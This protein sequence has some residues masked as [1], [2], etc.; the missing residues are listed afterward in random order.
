VAKVFTPEALLSRLRRD[1]RYEAISAVASLAVGL[2]LVWL[3]GTGASLS[4]VFLVFSMLVSGIFIGMCL[5]D[6]NMIDWFREGF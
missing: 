6:L 3:V 5:S 4:G 2:F 1:I